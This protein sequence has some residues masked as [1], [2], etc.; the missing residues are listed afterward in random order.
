[1]KTLKQI[2]EEYDNAYV[3]QDTPDEIMLEGNTGTTKVPG[4]AKMPTILVF[5]RVSYKLYP[6]KQT[7]AL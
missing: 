1:M 3:N 7:V 5:R 4:P 6:G 2:R